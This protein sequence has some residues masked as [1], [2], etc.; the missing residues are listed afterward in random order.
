MSSLS[1]WNTLNDI[2][3][4]LEGFTTPITRDKQSNIT[5]MAIKGI[6]LVFNELD[7]I[8]KFNIEKY[9]TC[10]RVLDLISNSK[11]DIQID[12][13]IK[14]INLLL[15][16]SMLEPAIA[17]LK[18]CYMLIRGNIY[19]KVLNNDCINFLDLII[20]IGPIPNSQSDV[21]IVSRF[22]VTTINVFVF[23]FK[24][25]QKID[26]EHS[27][28]VNSLA[29]NSTFDQILMSCPQKKELIVE[30]IKLMIQLSTLTKTGFKLTYLVLALKYGTY[31]DQINDDLQTKICNDCEK[32]MQKNE[33]VVY[34]LTSKPMFDL[35]LSFKD[36]DIKMDKFNNLITKYIDISKS[37]NIDNLNWE[38]FKLVKLETKHE[39]DF[40]I[41]KNPMELSQMFFKLKSADFNSIDDQRHVISTVELIN[42]YFINESKKT[43]NI[44]GILDFITINMKKV[45]LNNIEF[46]SHCLS[47]LSNIFS[48]NNQP[49]LKRLGNIATLNFFFGNKLVENGNEEGLLFLKSSAKIE[50]ALF[51]S[52]NDYEK[53]IKRMN[54]ISNSLIHNNFMQLS[55]PFLVRSLESWYEKVYDGNILNLDSNLDND[56]QTTLKLLTKS[57]SHTH[58]F[59]LLIEN[60]KYPELCIGSLV[61]VIKMITLSSILNKESI[62]SKII[63]AMKDSFT[64]NGLFLFFLSKIF[65]IIEFNI[66]F[67]SAEFEF[68][69]G[70]ISYPIKS[71]IICH[72]NSLT[73]S[74]NG[75]SG[76]TLIT[77]LKT[78]KH[79]MLE[80]LNTRSFIPISQYEFDVLNTVVNTFK[81][82]NLNSW[83]IEILEFYSSSASAIDSN[84]KCQLN[85]TLTK[86]YLNCYQF[87]KFIEI[88]DSLTPD[89]TSDPFIKIEMMISLLEYNILTNNPC[90]QD[91]LLTVFQILKNDPN[92]TVSNQKNKYIVVELLIILAK[93]SHVVSKYHK[94][95]TNDYVESISNLKRE[96]K[97]LQSIMKNFIL[98]NEKSPKFS[99]NFKCI[100]KLVFSENILNAYSTL[101]DT[102]FH[103]GSCKEFEYYFNELETFSQTQP[104]SILKFKFNL[105][106]TKHQI[107]LDN[108]SKV[109][110]LFDKVIGSSLNLDGIVDDLFKL[111][112]LSTMEKYYSF[113]NDINM[114]NESATKFDNFIISILSS[115]SNEFDSKYLTDIWIENIGRRL[116]SSR[117]EHFNSNIWI[118]YF[119]KSGNEHALALSLYDKCSN[120]ILNMPNFSNCTVSY[121]FSKIDIKKENGETS[122]EIIHTLRECGLNYSK[123]IDSNFQKIPVDILKNDINK[124]INCF[125]HLVRFDESNTEIDSVISMSDKFKYLPFIYER[126]LSFYDGVGNEVLPTLDSITTFAKTIPPNGLSLLSRIIP[127]NWIGISIDYSAIT[128][129]FTLVKYE[130]GYDKPWIFEVSL[131][132]KINFDSSI[133]NLEKIIEE[134]E[135]TTDPNVTCKISTS[136]Q[137]IEWWN[138]RKKLDSRLKDLLTNIENDWF[139]GF[140]SLFNTKK[141]NNDDVKNIRLFI[142]AWVGKSICD[143]KFIGMFD[144]FDDR[145]FELL[146]KIIGITK[147]KVRDILN[148]IFDSENVKFG[149]IKDSINLNKL[150][151]ELVRIIQL[152]SSSSNEKKEIDHIFII[153]GPESVSIPWESI[154]CLRNES[155]SR[156]PTVKHLMDRLI[157]EKSLIQ[158]GI[159]SENGYY[160]INPGGDLKRTENVLGPKFKE[161]AS[162]TGSIGAKPLESE[163]LR[164]FQNSNLYIYAGHG[165]GEQ[166]I[167]SS[168]IKK[169]DYIPPTLLFGCSSG[170]LKSKLFPYGTPYNYIMGGCPC[171][172]VNL[173]D[174]TDKD[175]DLFTMTVL[176][177]W[178]VLDDGFE[179]IG[180]DYFIQ[181]D[182]SKTLSECITKGRDVCKLKYLNGAAPVLYGLPLSL[183]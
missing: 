133:L 41:L 154:P 71:L 103:M 111:S 140:N 120:L 55:L 34:K 167:R 134:S 130:F 83:G 135:K 168:M 91:D 10:Q 182:E 78:I 59:Q 128:N 57:I 95:I 150:S 142:R 85:I 54:Q 180:E 132:E 20:E 60:F 53:F 11:R 39:L 64:D 61:V 69:S 67:K 118:E 44:I 125:I 90:V 162:W 117:N 19:K 156:F 56:M 109:E 49:D 179:S 14:L 93:F 24:V 102:L 113:K 145:L 4:S 16:K 129:C 36:H 5:K 28:L 108:R 178:G 105:E 23:S 48:I 45:T 25:E 3:V 47:I 122:D 74:L 107:S 153:P 63:I 70:S 94:F 139:G 127:K 172:L 170:K 177:E 84:F 157:N 7:S 115:N 143:P 15:S 96:V 76:A 104:S 171:L 32:M 126:G 42:S 175:T 2:S 38:T 58:H 174:V 124:L 27:E 155:I 6:N 99:M 18:V 89:M 13:Q 87:N 136:D 160:V 144:T 121:P 152:L 173:W 176:K 98:T 65:F 51:N 31:I 141:V 80:W 37:L 8:G 116:N 106:F 46:I 79:S 161:M 82:H 29:R 52:S 21:S 68:E 40:K 119:E 137:K 62:I 164:S 43:P 86:L 77:S 17:Q 1:L 181:C 75:T 138:T 26:V 30:L 92:F 158:G 169:Q 9:N 112:I 183:S 151:M 166:Y 110:S 149:L 88:S 148:I 147:E 131:N 165:G 100:L 97:I 146:L 123:S 114:A 35:L 72:L 12:Y 50:F 81:Y 66:N 22:L 163:I 33:N 73:L 101:T 159:S